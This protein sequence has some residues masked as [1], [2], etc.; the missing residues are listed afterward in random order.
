MAMTLLEIRAI[1]LLFGWTVVVW[2]LRMLAPGHGAG[3]KSE[4]VVVGTTDCCDD[5][6]PVHD[7]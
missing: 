7:V 4:N 6:R 5:L 3:V 1:V 2:K